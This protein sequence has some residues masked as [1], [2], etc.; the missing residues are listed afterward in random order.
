MPDLNVGVQFPGEGLIVAIINAL[1][2]RRETM[3][4]ANR[5]REDDILLDFLE[6]VKAWTKEVQA[7]I[8]AAGG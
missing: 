2:V 3:S 8:K 6:D 5:D 1:A 7:K 4:Q